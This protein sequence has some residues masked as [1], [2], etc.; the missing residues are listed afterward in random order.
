MPNDDPQS[1][2]SPE[3]RER[4][5]KAIAD[6]WEQHP[7]LRLGQLVYTY[8]LEAGDGNIFYIK[9]SLLLERLRK[10]LK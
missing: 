10:P 8:V 3:H 7:H 4:M 5:L 2:T 9:D 1:P 6:A